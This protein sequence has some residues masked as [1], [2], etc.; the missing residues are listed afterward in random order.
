[1]Y[2]GLILV[3]IGVLLALNEMGL[4]KGS[5]WGYLLPIVMIVMGVYLIQKKNKQRNF[6]VSGHDKQD[7]AREVVDEQ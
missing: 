5:F 1:M 7:K 4:I 2:I 3:I 6:K